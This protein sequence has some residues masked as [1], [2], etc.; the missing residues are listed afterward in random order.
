MTQGEETPGQAQ[1]QATE[2]P[3]EGR[4]ASQGVPF[5][6]IFT[7]AGAEEVGRPQ[8]GADSWQT[9]PTTGSASPPGMG[10]GL[11]TV[12]K[13]LAFKLESDSSLLARG[14]GNRA[15]EQVRRDPTLTRRRM[16][17]AGS[18]PPSRQPGAFPPDAFSFS[19]PLSFFHRG[20]KIRGVWPHRP[21]ASQAV[22]ESHPPAHGGGESTGRP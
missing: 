18:T 12:D 22:V 8:S 13:L 7:G 11:Q 9:L 5:C 10:A 16:K 3:S 20:R 4:D 2:C 14:A 1:A 6:R 21:R 19:L 15:Q 17:F